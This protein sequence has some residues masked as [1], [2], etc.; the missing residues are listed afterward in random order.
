MWLRLLPPPQIF[1]R[2]GKTYAP[3]LLGDGSHHG[4]GLSW[5][6]KTLVDSP[7]LKVTPPAAALFSEP[8]PIAV[9]AGASQ[10]AVEHG[11]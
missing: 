6:A 11:I 10:D 9:A 4:G 1:R 2:E 3:L 5:F 7:S 8:P